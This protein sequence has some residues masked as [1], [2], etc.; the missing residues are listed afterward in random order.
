M[1]KRVDTI[2][3]LEQAYNKAVEE[4]VVNERARIVGLFDAEKWSLEREISHQTLLR[5]QCI[6]EGL[7]KSPMDSDRCG[8]Y[9]D[10]WAEIGKP[11]GWRGCSLKKG[12]EGYHTD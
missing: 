3:Q 6:I 11:E 9:A 5:Y 12:H 8:A 4:A 2:I 10:Q 7:R 1:K